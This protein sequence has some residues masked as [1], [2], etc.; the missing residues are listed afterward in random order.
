MP[1]MVKISPTILT[2]KPAPLNLKGSYLE[3]LLESIHLKELALHDQL[4]HMTLL[5]AAM[6]TSC[7]LLLLG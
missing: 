3:K 2:I 4:L 7:G 5:N 6:G 1:W